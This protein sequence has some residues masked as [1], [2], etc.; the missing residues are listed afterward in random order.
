MSFVAANNIIYSILSTLSNVFRY[1][2]KENVLE[3]LLQLIIHGFQRKKKLLL[4]S[5]SLWCIYFFIAFLIMFQV[6]EYSTILKSVHSNFPE[7]Y[8]Q[9][10]IE[11]SKL[12]WNFKL[13]T[14][15]QHKLEH[16]NFFN[17]FFFGFFCFDFGLN[18][19]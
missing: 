16:W 11:K 2:N 7:K 3:V 5:C 12:N 6:F 10:N 19:L 4:V 17:F 18:K 14:E 9:R 8:A 1:K 13:I 15:Y